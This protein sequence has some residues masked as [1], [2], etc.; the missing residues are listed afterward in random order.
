[1]RYALRYDGLDQLF[2]AFRRRGFRL[3]GPVR[4]DGAT[5]GWRTSPASSR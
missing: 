2:D 5:S 1:M 3:V 4:R